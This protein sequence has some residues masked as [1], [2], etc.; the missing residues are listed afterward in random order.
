[1]SDDYFFGDEDFNDSAF[2]A[3][4][5]AFEATQ[6]FQPQQQATKPSP[7]PAL[8]AARPAFQSPSRPAPVPVAS[9]S[10]SKPPPAEV[11]NISDD[12]EFKFDDSFDLENADWEGFDQRTE[13]QAQQPQKGTGP[14][15]GP[16][17]AA[18][19]F[20]R[21]SSGKLQQ[22]TLWGLPAPPE[23]R[24]KLPP[25]QKGKSI[26]KTKTWDRT[27]YAKT[28]WMATKK[29]KNKSHNSDGEEEE[30]EAVDYVQFP[31]PANAGEVYLRLVLDAGRLTGRW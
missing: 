29:G 19:Q 10:R 21:T 3:G 17:V 14:V 30:E 31:R 23:N 24:N 6:N 26:K 9:T 27:E 25:R 22:Q 12:E 20:T 7:S 8:V 18:R 1:M 16:S 13:V 2:I 15:P 4:L 11:I 5:D 28:G